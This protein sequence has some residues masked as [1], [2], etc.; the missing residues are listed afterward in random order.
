MAELIKQEFGI[1]VELIKGGMGE[2]A[3][4]VDGEKV[5]KKG[6]FTSPSEQE[7]L[8]AVREAIK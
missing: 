4:L 7:I 8:N 2:L 1:E 5:A 3:V 6:W